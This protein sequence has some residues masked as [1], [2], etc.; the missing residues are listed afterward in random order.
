MSQ[1][2]TMWRAATAAAMGGALLCGCATSP[3]PLYQWEGYQPQVYEYF[4][5]E[6]REAQ[7]ISLER[8]LE[9]I[10][11]ANNSVPPGFHAHLGLLY[12]ATGKDD[13]MIREFT[14]EKQLF[15]ESAAY[16]DFLLSNKKKGAN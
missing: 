16:I 9:R 10:K 6:S 12:A 8:D 14:T 4:K 1:K 5:G 13:M 7:V 15:P 3:K 2:F 11:A